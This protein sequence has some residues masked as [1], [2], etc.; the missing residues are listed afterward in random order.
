MDLQQLGAAIVAAF[1]V[2]KL[3]DALVR[4]I[5]DRFELDTFWL[6]YVALVIGA[7]LGWFTGINALPVFGVEPV[8]GRILTCLLIGLGPSFIHD[9]V[10]QQPELPK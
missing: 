8:V 7:G 2:M 6:M 10:S 3:V 1:V 5:W 9:L 4:P